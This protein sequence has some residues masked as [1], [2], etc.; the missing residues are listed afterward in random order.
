MQKLSGL[1]QTVDSRLSIFKRLL[2]LSGRLDL[3]MSQVAMRGTTNEVKEPETSAT[4]YNGTVILF[5]CLF[6]CLLC[7]LTI[8]ANHSPVDDEE[9]SDEDAMGFGD[10]DADYLEAD[11]KGKKSKKSRSNG[12]D[13]EFGFET[14][15]DEDNEED[16]E[17]EDEEDEEDEGE[18][19]AREND[20]SGS[21]ADDDEDDE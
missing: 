20:E 3:I 2:R 9:V 19:G 12:Q 14:E 10:D 5:A 18:N 21:E 8:I 1:Y 7:F 4:V 17:D 6:V 13:S 11:S 16:E 15:E